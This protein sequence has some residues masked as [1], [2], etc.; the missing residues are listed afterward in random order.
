MQT[1]SDFPD[2]YTAGD[3]L[4]FNPDVASLAYDSMI[5]KAMEEVLLKF[6]PICFVVVVCAGWNAEG[7]QITSMK[8]AFCAKQLSLCR[9]TIDLIRWA[10]MNS[11][12][13]W[14]YEYDLVSVPKVLYQTNRRDH[15]KL[16]RLNVAALCQLDQRTFYDDEMCE[17][18]ILRMLGPRALTHYKLLR[19]AAH[20]ADFFRYVLLFFEGGI[21]LDI[22]SCFLE[23]LSCLLSEC[24]SCSVLTCI[25]AG[26]S[27]IHQGI[28]MCPAGHPL[29]HAAIHKVMETRPSSLGSRQPGYMTFC[30]QMWD[31]LQNRS[32]SNL[33]I[34]RNALRDWGSVWLLKERKT[35]LRCIHINSEP[36]QIDG[37]LAYMRGLPQ[38]VVAIRCE[39]WKHGFKGV[40]D[41]NRI[42]AIAEM[43]TSAL[44]H[45][46]PTGI[47][48]LDKNDVLLAK[49]AAIARV[50]RQY[51]TYYKSLKAEELSEFTLQGLVAT[52]GG[53]LGCQHHCIKGRP[54]KFAAAFCLA[55]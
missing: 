5:S 25:G 30:R 11:G 9:T 50:I 45:D 32:V 24:E 2:L 34:G 36:I 17:T 47:M 31:L 7:S 35:P 33:Q 26:N 3:K 13:C 40:L 8:E 42:G 49:E 39:G 20:R 44:V 48:E 29:L 16:Q 27:H 21:Y 12:C 54:K 15:E 4:H 18:Y 23:S 19:M 1:R 52:D 38:P 28:L 37:Y 43:N 22:K 51:P 46:A 10:K 55:I 53:W 14:K 41:M 6:G